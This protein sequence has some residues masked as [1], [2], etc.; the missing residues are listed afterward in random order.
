MIKIGG[1]NGTNAPA[2]QSGINQAADSYSRE[3]Q[4]RI[5]DAQK[6]LQELS[7]DESMTLEEKMKK[8]QEIQ[9]EINDLNL[10]LRQHQIAQRKEQQS[11][12]NAIEDG[13]AG[14]RRTGS[15]G[16]DIRL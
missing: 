4:S 11:K 3:I 8:R 5:A 2:G 6:R 9:Q 15:G 10:Q 7:S 12:N 14:G 16:A 13:T 1:T